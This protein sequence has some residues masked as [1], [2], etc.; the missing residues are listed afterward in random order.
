MTSDEV[1]LKNG[2]WYYLWSQSVKEDLG[3]TSKHFSVI[4][5]EKWESIIRGKIKLEDHLHVIFQEKLFKDQAITP[6]QYI[7]YW[8]THDHQVNQDILE[9][10]KSLKIPCY[11][12]TN[13]EA[14]R[15]AHILNTAGAYFKEC[16]ASYNIG[17]IKPEQGFF[18]YIQKALSLLPHE[19]L[20][21]DD[22]KNNILGAQSCSLH[23]YHY[24]NDTRGLMDF[25]KKYELANESSH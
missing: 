24:Q 11:L 25:L 6:E 19:L 17:S 10:V 9:L 13:Q 22:T 8:L 4:F 3:L 14:L 5:S 7:H 2:I 15:T 23:V 20:L 16:F 12:G 21:I 18:Q 1:V